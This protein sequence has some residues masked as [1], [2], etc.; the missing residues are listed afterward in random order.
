MMEHRMERNKR[1]KTK[2]EK[3]RNERAQIVNCTGN[4]RVFFSLPV[5]VPVI[6]PYPPGGYRF[7]CGSAHEYPGIDPL[8]VPVAGYPWV[9]QLLSTKYIYCY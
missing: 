9:L 5:P 7:F 8:P 2:Q 6:N 4:P 1:K 3:R